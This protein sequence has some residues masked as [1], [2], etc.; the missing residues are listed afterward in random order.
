MT[1]SSHVHPK[2]KQFDL[3]AK[4]KVSVSNNQFLFF[5]KINLDSKNKIN[6]ENID[7]NWAPISKNRLFQNKIIKWWCNDRKWWCNETNCWLIKSSK[8][9]EHHKIP[10]KLLIVMDPNFYVMDN[11]NISNI[12][13]V[14][15][16]WHFALGALQYIFD[17]FSGV[18][19]SIS[20]AVNDK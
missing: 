20:Q 8:L 10:E 15:K 4:M 13:F 16:V 11:K 5:L 6:Q 12:V 18:K 17:V 9:N 3:Y 1:K 2:Q 19:C 14:G 7:D